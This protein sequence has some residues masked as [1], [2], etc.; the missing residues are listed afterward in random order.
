VL[1]V[2]EEED[3]VSVHW[4]ERGWEER[5]GRGEE[6]NIVV[7]NEAIFRSRWAFQTQREDV[8]S[9]FLGLAGRLNALRNEGV[10]T[11]CLEALKLLRICLGK[12]SEE[13]VKCF[14]GS[15]DFGS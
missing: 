12:V 3:S 11:T 2:T 7:M 9:A 6:T 10:R 15:E 5:G 14:C 4:G 1:I 13:F 8:L